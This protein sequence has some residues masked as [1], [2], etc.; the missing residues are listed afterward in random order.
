MGLPVIF[1]VR[2]L[3]SHL[4]NGIKLYIPHYSKPPCQVPVVAKHIP[5]RWSSLVSSRLLFV[6][7]DCHSSSG[8]L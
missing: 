8:L 6:Q 4:E 3:I 2:M 1:L 7:E 5:F